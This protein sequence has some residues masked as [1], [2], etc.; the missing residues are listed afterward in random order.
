MTFDKI[1]IMIMAVGI[2]IGG[3]DR[4]LDNKFGLGEKFEEGFNS[5][6]PLALG[7]VGIV[8]LAPVISKVL[9]PIIIPIYE[10]IGADPA[11]FASI[12]ANDMGGYPLA[13]SLA[14]NPEA[15]MLSGLIVASMLGCTIV[16]SIPVGLGLIEN[17]DRTYFAKGLLIGLVTVP[18]GGIVGG[19]LAGFDFGMV[20]INNVP[21]IIISALLAIGLKFIPNMMIKGALFFGKFI[22]WVI[23]IG[24]AASAFEALTGIVIIPGMAPITDGLEV[25]A[26]IGIVLLGTFPI[27][28]LLV[29]VLDKPLNAIGRKIGLDSTSAA[30]VVFTLANS[31][32]VYKMIKD[33]N[34]R[35]KIVN[36]AWLVPAT[37]A[38]GDHLGFTAGVSPEMIT[39]VVVSKLVAGVVA[40]GLALFMTRDLT[41]KAEKVVSSTES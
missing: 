17:K 31:I 1:I 11:M 22:L 24:L 20:L 35:G 30:G 3:I 14:Q 29:K 41:V 7:M 18:V 19:L 15:G 10:A 9:G 4:I 5:M 27:L 6:G 21:I 39:P 36:I 16:F 23:T 26:S 12:L 33:M 13:M 40:V 8:T 25:V 38:L 32:P 34:P 37:A 28:T 2:L